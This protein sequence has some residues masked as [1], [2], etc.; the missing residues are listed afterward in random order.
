MPGLPIRVWARIRGEVTDGARPLETETRLIPQ[1]IRR[2]FSDKSVPGL[3]ICSGAPTR[4]ISPARPS[5]YNVSIDDGY[6]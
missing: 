2:L 1:Q 4:M 6:R 3:Y 5:T